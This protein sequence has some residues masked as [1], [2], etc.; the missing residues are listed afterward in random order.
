[1]VGLLLLLLMYIRCK[2]LCEQSDLCSLKP[3]LEML[4][5]QGY[6]AVMINNKYFRGFRFGFSK[7][8][9]CEGS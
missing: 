7:V 1:M 5:W 9:V 4:E 8:G 3:K 2:T 6:A